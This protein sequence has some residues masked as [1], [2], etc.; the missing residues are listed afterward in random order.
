M[1]MAFGVTKKYPN[2]LRRGGVFKLWIMIIGIV[3]VKCLKC[4]GLN[5]MSLEY[6]TYPLSEITDEKL[7]YSNV[8]ETR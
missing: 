2:V 5:V 6:I 1:N 8:L 3:R 4:F 7:W